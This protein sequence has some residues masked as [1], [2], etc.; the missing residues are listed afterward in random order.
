M[1]SIL[2]LCQVHS[3]C[4]GC[5]THPSSGVQILTVSTATGTNHSIVSANYSQCG[6]VPGICWL[7]Q[8]IYYDA[9][10][11]KHKRMKQFTHILVT[12]LT[13]CISCQTIHNTQQMRKSL[14]QIMKR[15]RA[16]TKKICFTANL[17]VLS[18]TYKTING[19]PFTLGISKQINGVFRVSQ[20]FAACNGFLQSLSYCGCS[21]H[22]IQYIR[23]F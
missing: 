18:T 4:F 17:P 5:S 9:W 16:Q 3:T 22:F 23:Y 15:C 2:F 10:N 14:I 6:L 21:A 12:S 1:Q 8:R 20:T 7:F 11:L 19:L 13:E